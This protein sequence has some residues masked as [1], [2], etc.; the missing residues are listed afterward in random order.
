MRSAAATNVELADRRRSFLFF[1]PLYVE[2]PSSR[3]SC[4]AL[5]LSR[6][7]LKTAFDHLLTRGMVHGDVEQVVGGSGLQAAKLMDQ[8]LAGCPGE[9]CADDVHADDIGKGVAPFM[10]TYGCNPAGTHWAPAGNS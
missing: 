7:P 9:E 1:L 2:G 4:L 3:S 10:R 6:P 8:G 5:P